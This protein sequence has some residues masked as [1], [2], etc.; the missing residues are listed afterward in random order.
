MKPCQVLTNEQHLSLVREERVAALALYLLFLIHR[1]KTKRLPAPPSLPSGVPPLCLQ[2][3]ALS[4][5][6]QHA[7]SGICTFATQLSLRGMP[8]SA[9]HTPFSW[10]TLSHH[11][12][13]RP[14]CTSPRK[15]LLTSTSPAKV[16]EVFFL[17]VASE[18]Q[19]SLCHCTS[20]FYASA[21]P[22]RLS[23]TWK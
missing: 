12:R 8:P 1:I 11:L 6:Q 22:I 2:W 3:T 5:L 14:E 21:S 20:S 18:L 16:R 7:A 13:H 15:S 23:T 9:S 17:C 10:P 19:A 4:P